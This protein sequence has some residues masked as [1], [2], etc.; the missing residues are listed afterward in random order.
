MVLFWHVFAWFSIPNKRN[1]DYILGGLGISH[2]VLHQVL[3]LSMS[4]LDLLNSPEV[5]EEPA[6]MMGRTVTEFCSGI[7]RWL[8]GN[9]SGLEQFFVI[10]AVEL[11]SKGHPHCCCVLE[12]SIL[13]NNKPGFFSRDGK[14]F[15]EPEFLTCGGNHL[16]SPPVLRNIKMRINH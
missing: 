7:C 1:A 6:E 3:E 4:M 8:V 15:P 14:I 16:H 5:D 11:S 10:F 13:E 12:F 2:I 9:L